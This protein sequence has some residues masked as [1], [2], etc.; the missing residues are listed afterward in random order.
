MI[1]EEQDRP[2]IVSKVKYLGSSLLPSPIELEATIVLYHNRMH[3]PELDAT[4]TIDKVSQIELAKGK[5]LSSEVIMMFGVV[6]LIVEKENSYMM[7]K[8]VNSP[9]SLLFRFGDTIIA[10]MLVKE[11]KAIQHS[12]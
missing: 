6:G 10:E 2:I 7:I 11:I 9:D 3:I 1:A 8:I 12:K 5:D 4:I